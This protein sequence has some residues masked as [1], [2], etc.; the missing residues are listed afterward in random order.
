MRSFQVT[1]HPQYDA[2]LE[3]TAAG[4]NGKPANQKKTLLVL[5]RQRINTFW[6]NKEDEPEEE[7]VGL[8]EWEKQGLWQPRAIEL[9]PLFIASQK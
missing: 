1:S 8:H 3:H 6:K 9:D 4:R 7:A 5:P 2:G